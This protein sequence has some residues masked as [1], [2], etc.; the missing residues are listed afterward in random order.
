[1]SIWDKVTSLAKELLG[2]EPKPRVNLSEVSE[3]VNRPRK[4][5]GQLGNKPQK[6]KAVDVSDIEVIP[7]YLFILEAV[8]EGCPAL[9]VT[10]KAGTGKSTMIRYL[11][12]KMKKCAVVAPT[13]IAA[14]NVGGSTI[15]SFFGIPPRTLNPDEAF[16]P[17]RHMRPVLENLEVLIVD[18]VSMVSPDLIDCMNNCLKQVKGSKE[19][20]GGV[21]IIFVG[22]ILQLPPVVSQEAE[23]VYYTHRYSS[24]YFYSADVFKDIEIMPLEL[25]KVFRQ[26]DDLFIS[27]LDQVRCNR[28]LRDALQLLNENCLI[29]S[30]SDEAICLVPTNAGS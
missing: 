16:N 8:K 17:N 19:S 10:G 9:F 5:T 13:A 1:M 23:G 26:Q 25:K 27:A 4:S 14:I 2:E 22:D 18:E 30:E 6:P 3:Q 7:E 15:H 28:N 29:T 11:T 24:P 21:P 20:F 12:A